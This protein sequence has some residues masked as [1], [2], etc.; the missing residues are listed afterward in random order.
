MELFFVLRE[1]QL[2][3]GHSLLSRGEIRLACANYRSGSG[4]DVGVSVAVFCLVA[5]LVRKRSLQ[6]GAAASSGS[7]SLQN[8]KKGGGRLGLFSGWF[9]EAKNRLQ[10]GSLGGLLLRLSFLVPLRSEGRPKEK[11]LES[12]IRRMIGGCYNLRL[13]GVLQTNH[14]TGILRRNPVTMSTSWHMRG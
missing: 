4:V 8:N 6:N 14:S 1:S 11:P 12:P 13:S 5:R 7:V 2:G 3:L 9:G 10:L